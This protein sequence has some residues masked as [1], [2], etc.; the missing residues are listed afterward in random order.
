MRAGRMRSAR[1]VVACRG[2]QE[3]RCG[4]RPASGLRADRPPRPGCPDARRESG[5]G[6]SEPVVHHG[7]FAGEADPQA[8][9]SALSLFCRTRDMAEPLRAGGSKLPSSAVTPH[10]RAGGVRRGQAQQSSSALTCWLTAAS[11]SCQ[12]R[13]RPAGSFRGVR[14]PRRR[15]C[16]QRRKF[17]D[18]MTK[19]SLLMGQ[20]E[21]ALSRPEL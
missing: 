2:G 15:V 13:S 17:H 10:N 9:A 12:V 8:A 1:P 4:P 14:R 3:G 19:P 16:G 20:G 11:P 6:G 7:R 18:L 5:A 21:R